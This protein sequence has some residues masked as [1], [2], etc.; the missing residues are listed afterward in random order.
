MP[1]TLNAL[2]PTTDIN[3]VVQFVN[4]QGVNG[5]SPE[6]FYEKQLLDT[7][8][9]DEASFVYFRYADEQPIQDRADKLTLRRWAPLQ[10]HT[11]PLAEGVPPKSDKGS[12]EKYE[13]EAYSYG[14]YM[15]FSDK[16]DYKAVDPLIAHYTQEYAIV[17]METL[18]LLA[19]DMLLSK[20]QQ[21]YAGG[22]SA[23]T[24]LRIATAGPTIA[25]LRLI[26]LSL[27]KLLVKP[28]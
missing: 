27:K 16:V 1:I 11:V 14:R 12:F 25:D 28:R 9:L 26:Q 2:S 24:E 10:A 17:A 22:A 21:R 5:I 20:A 18:D 23:L 13:M 3:S 15:E 8:R 6:V 7:I 19:R 4:A